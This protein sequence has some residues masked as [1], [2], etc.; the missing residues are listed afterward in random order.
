MNNNE[1]TI[2]YHI[3]N[4]TETLKKL[5]P[6]KH[7]SFTSEGLIAIA[8]KRQDVEDRTLLLG[9]NPGDYEIIKIL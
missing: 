5:H 4:L 7:A 6:G 2:G 1:R 8:S 3:N 9:N